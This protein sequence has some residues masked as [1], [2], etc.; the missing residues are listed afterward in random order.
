MHVH[1]HLHS[2][3]GWLGLLELTSRPRAASR[4]PLIQMKLATSN[5]GYQV[6]LDSHADAQATLG[7]RGSSNYMPNLYRRVQSSCM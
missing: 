6:V 4:I 2:L 3:A 7:L 1:V 5:V